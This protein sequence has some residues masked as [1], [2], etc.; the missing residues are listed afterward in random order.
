[1]VTWLSFAVSS[2]SAPHQTSGFRAPSSP[3]CLQWDRLWTPGCPMTT[4]SAPSVQTLS[5]DLRSS[6]LT[7]CK[8]SL[9]LGMV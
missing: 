7:S 1:M 6:H 8:M 2:S 3:Y 9:Q 5:P 4:T